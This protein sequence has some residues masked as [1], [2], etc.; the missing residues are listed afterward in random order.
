MCPSLTSGRVYMSRSRLRDGC[1][2]FRSE[3]REYVH[4]PD[5]DFGK[6]C[7]CRDVDFGE[8]VHVPKSN[9]GRCG[10]SEVELSFD[11]DVPISILQMFFDK[12]WPDRYENFARLRSH[13]ELS[14]TKRFF[15]YHA[16]AC[17]DLGVSQPSEPVR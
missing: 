11:V 10:W 13:L 3:T 7:T 1:G 6:T 12:N 15:R 2:C 14:H 17:L 5:V 4:L 8:R 16:L 9:A